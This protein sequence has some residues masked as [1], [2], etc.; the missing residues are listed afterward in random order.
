CKGE[1][2]IEELERIEISKLDFNTKKYQPIIDLTKEGIIRAV[3]KY[4]SLYYIIT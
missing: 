1:H 2:I 4:K 3:K